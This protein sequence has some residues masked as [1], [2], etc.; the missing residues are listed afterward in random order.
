M[1]RTRFFIESK[2]PTPRD[3]GK[4]W[5]GWDVAQS[6]DYSGVSVLQK[7]GTG[8]ALLYLERLPQ[9]MEY[10]AQ[11]DHI[12]SLLSRKELAQAEKTLCIDATG[13]GAPIVDEANKRGLNPVSVTITAGNAPHWNDDKS[14][15]RC[16]KKDLVSNLVVLAQGGSMKIADGLHYADVLSKELSSFEVRVNPDTRNVSFGNW[17]REGA[18]DD[19]VLSVAL[20]LYVAEYRHAR[21]HGVFRGLTHTRYNR[22]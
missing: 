3:Y 17:P 5:I 14:R 6:A 16:P 10:P 12:Q 4:F 18:H 9:G 19:L 13:V 2:S 20:A 8:Y 21:T 22:Y 7:I 1:T 15:L 11:M